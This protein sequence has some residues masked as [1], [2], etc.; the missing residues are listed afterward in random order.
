[1]LRRLA[2]LLFFIF[3]APF[4]E[5]FAKIC[6]ASKEY[7][8]DYMGSSGSSSTSSA[9]RGSKIRLNPAL[10]PIAKGFGAEFLYFDQEVDF[11]LVK[12]LGRIGAAI[13]PSNS[14]ETFFG[15]PGIE[16]PNELLLRKRGMHKFPNQKITLGTAFGLYDNKRS[17][18]ERL[19]FNLG[20]MGRY[21]K[22]TSS[23]LG[24]GGIS[25]VIGPVAIGVSTY[26]DETQL[27]TVVV[28]GAPLVIP[29]QVST[30]SVGAFYEGLAVDYS[31]LNV[32]SNQSANVSVW[33]GTI[34]WKNLIA[35]GA[36]R[37]ENL[38]RPSYDYATDTVILV[39][40]KVE[41]F[42]GLQVSI[43]DPLMV[44]VFYNYYL[45]REVSFGAT[46]FF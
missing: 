8:G 22:K 26:K 31:L 9:G 25:S 17:G 42:G 23:V 6:D 38:T 41:Y 34:V 11:A 13:S 28:N 46:L 24:G 15:P 37:T 43:F 7:C 40:K 39:D 10:M 18:F 2:A 1:M 44:G 32:N 36:M 27:D 12:G 21:N 45:M 4:P 3:F 33:T 19:A 5:A 35:T 30:F 14:E 16:D 20:V 29:Y